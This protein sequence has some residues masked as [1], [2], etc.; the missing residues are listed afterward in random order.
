[1]TA[2]TGSIVKSWLQSVGS[3]AL[4]QAW[5][6]EELG[7]QLVQSISISSNNIFRNILGTARDVQTCLMH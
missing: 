6:V 4:G 2:C 5:N 3:L 1:M 7:N